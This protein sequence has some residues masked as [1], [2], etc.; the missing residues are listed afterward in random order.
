MDLR[1]LTRRITAAPVHR[2]PPVRA[3]SRST[4]RG[5]PPFRRVGALDQTAQC[6]P[7]HVGNIGVGE[8]PAHSQ[9]GTASLQENITAFDLHRAR[10]I[11]NDFEFIVA[12]RNHAPDDA[13]AVTLFKPAFDLKPESR[14]RLW[15]FLQRAEQK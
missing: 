15:R 14:R 4:V 10:R 8:A 2:A 9:H 5:S 12:E 11:R 1:P 13:A 6:K 7:R 3:T